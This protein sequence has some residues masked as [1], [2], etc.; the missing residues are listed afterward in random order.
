MKAQKGRAVEQKDIKRA[1]AL[2][3]ILRS[4]ICEREDQRAKNVFWN[5]H[6]GLEGMIQT[7]E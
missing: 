7:S 5:I 4:E 6:P 2:I 3:D 1:Q